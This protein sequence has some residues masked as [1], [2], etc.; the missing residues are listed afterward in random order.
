[1]TGTTGTT[2]VTSTEPSS[3][4]STSSTTETT[5]TGTGSG[6]H[7]LPGT[8]LDLHDWRLGLPTDSKGGTK[9]TSRQIKQPQ[10]LT[11]TDK[12]FLVNPAADGVVF[13]AGVGG[14]TTPGSKYPRSEL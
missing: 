2:S 6:G 1:T 7:V 11:Y 8:I 12:N 4:T 10:L 14:A 5:S 13:T 3:T 9:G